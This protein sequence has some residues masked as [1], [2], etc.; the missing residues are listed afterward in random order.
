MPRLV[1]LKL[2]MLLLP[3]TSCGSA[4][5]QPWVRSAAAAPR[6]TATGDAA[7]GVIDVWVLPHAHCDVGWLKTVEGYYRD[8]AGREAWRHAHCSCHSAFV[9]TPMY[10][11]GTT[12]V[13]TGGHWGYLV[14]S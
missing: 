8:Q 14:P 5:L 13:P 3:H 12:C 4:Q 7:A 11:A 9:H 1:L 10:H 6:S 2:L